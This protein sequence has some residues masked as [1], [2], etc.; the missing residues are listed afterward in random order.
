MTEW[1]DFEKEEEIK[2]EKVKY[3]KLQILQLA[4]EWGYPG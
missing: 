4:P 3:E 2:E 1:I